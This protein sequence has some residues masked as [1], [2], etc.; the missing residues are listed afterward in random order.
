M[1][2]KLLLLFI[3]LISTLVTAQF[4]TTT[5]VPVLKITP[6][7][8]IYSKTILKGVIE[9]NGHSFENKDSD[10]PIILTATLQNIKIH[11]K[12]DKKE[13]TFR[14]CGKEDCMI[15]HLLEKQN[16]TI[17]ITNKYYFNA[18]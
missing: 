14:Q 2:N 10:C 15:I 17:P 16:F 7:K 1:K 5:Q 11:N 13:Y 8:L 6:G 4:K 18:N 3:L 12:C 9:I